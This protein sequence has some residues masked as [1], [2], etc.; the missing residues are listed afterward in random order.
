M[1]SLVTIPNT[2]MKS[3]KYCVNHELWQTHSE[4]M[5]GSSADG[6]V[7]TN[8]QF[9][10]NLKWSEAHRQGLKLPWVAWCP[11]F[12]HLEWWSPR[13]HLAAPV[14]PGERS[15]QKQL[16]EP[17]RH[18]LITWCNC[19]APAGW[20]VGVPSPLFWG[21]ASRASCAHPHGHA[22]WAGWALLGGSPSP[23]WHW[24]WGHPYNPWACAPQSLESLQGVII[25]LVWNRFVTE[26]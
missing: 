14:F 24:T 13:G 4:H 23:P 5:L 7:G 17:W 20:D 25:S 16:C 8:L 9:C 26:E 12:H 6:R 11:A 22:D 18:F 3:L 21:S 15:F 2:V 1:A 19:R 10:K